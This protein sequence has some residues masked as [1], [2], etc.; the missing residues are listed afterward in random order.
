[1]RKRMHA[2]AVH[3]S[4]TDFF[5][6]LKKNM[7]EESA[8]AITKV[9]EEF[10]LQ[11][12]EVKTEVR[13]EIREEI[14]EELNFK[15]LATKQDLTA[16]ALTTKQDLAALELRTDR[17]IESTVNKAKWHLIGMMLVIFVIPLLL[18]HYGV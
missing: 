2:Q 1:M 3:F 15:D 16:L 14:R 5:V 10:S 7:D 11:R 13:E 8:Q 18:K 12:E 6:K 9:F 17:K 4:P